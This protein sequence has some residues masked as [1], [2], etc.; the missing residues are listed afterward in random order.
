MRLPKAYQAS[1][2]IDES[3]L[4]FLP[5][6]DASSVRSIKRGI[7]FILAKWSG[8]SQLA[9]RA[10]NKALASFPDLDGLFLYVADADGDRTEELVSALGDVPGGAGETYWLVEGQVQ[11]KLCGYKEGHCLHFR[12]TPGTSYRQ[13]Y[14]D[15]RRLFGWKKDF[16]MKRAFGSPA[17]PTKLKRGRPKYQRRT[18][19]CSRPGPP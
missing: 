14:K 2:S 10:L 18:I 6:A 12:T 15:H 3:R 1:L 17:G 13:E 9:F 8:A 11:H 4:V 19:R 7:L 16:K 5:D